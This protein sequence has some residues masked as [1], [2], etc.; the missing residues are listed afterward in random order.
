MSIKSKIV[1][2]FIHHMEEEAIEKLGT[3]G[4]VEAPG[5]GIILYDYD[6]NTFNVEPDK[7]ILSAV[8]RTWERNHR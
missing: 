3:S 6:E 4:H 8:R 1:D 7:Q 5:I 2:S